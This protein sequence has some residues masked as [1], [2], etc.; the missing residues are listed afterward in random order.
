MDLF[1]PLGNVCRTTIHCLRGSLGID[2]DFDLYLVDNDAHTHKTSLDCIPPS[3][4]P[5][6]PRLA[7]RVSRL[8][9]V[10]TP[11]AQSRPLRGTWAICPH[12]PVTNF[13][14]CPS[15]FHR[16]F[17][18]SMSCS[19]LSRMSRNRWA[20][21]TWN[22]A[23]CNPPPRTGDAFARVRPRAPCNTLSH[24]RL[25][26][27]RRRTYTWAIRWGFGAA[28]TRQPHSL[29]PNLSMPHCQC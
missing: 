26:P 22:T 4:P 2:F 19:P 25:L 8:C 15:Q 9:I 1:P 3:A 28:P 14:R 27:C 7:Q 6:P 13:L 21:R 18:P 12:N 23:T 29:F 11:L 16:S 17:S 20:A 24:T 5:P 10:R